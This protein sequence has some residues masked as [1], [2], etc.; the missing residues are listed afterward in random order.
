MSEF[1]S[2]FPDGLSE[3]ESL[4]MDHDDFRQIVVDVAHSR[5]ALDVLAS[6]L[7]SGTADVLDRAS[8]TGLAV[9][10]ES[11]TQRL[12][13]ALDGLVGAAAA[14]QIEGVPELTAG[15]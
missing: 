1:T 8:G 10:L 7:Y 6:L 9:L 11:S 14:L 15:P 3:P 2:Q 12:Q 13:L 5:R 4:L